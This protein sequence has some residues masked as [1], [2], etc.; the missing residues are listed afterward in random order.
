MPPLDRELTLKPRTFEC[1]RVRGIGPLAQATTQPLV[2]GT[3]APSDGLDELRVAV[4]HEIE[5]GRG[6]GVLLAHEQQRDERRQHQQPG[7]ELQGFEVHQLRQAF[8]PRPVPHLIVVLHADHESL[9]GDAVGRR[10]VPALPELRVLARI[11]V[12][13][14]EGLGQVIGRAEVLV[15]ALA[16]PREQGVDRMMEVVA[17]LG[18]HAQAA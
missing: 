18:V 13:V 11:G 8:A 12:S 3:P 4:V 5:E 6:F 9:T 2:L 7:G 14:A 10:A 16:F 1:V 17:P 15:V